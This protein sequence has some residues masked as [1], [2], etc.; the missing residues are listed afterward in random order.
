MQ[1]RW[2]RNLELMK[3]GLDWRGAADRQRQS[4]WERQPSS[5]S[6]NLLAFIMTE[7]TRTGFPLDRHGYSQ[8][9]TWSYMSLR[10]Q[11]S[12]IAVSW[13]FPSECLMTSWE[14]MVGTHDVTLQFCQSLPHNR[15]SA[16]RSI[17]GKVW[18]YPTGETPEVASEWHC[19]LFAT[20]WGHL[21]QTSLAPPGWFPPSLLQPP[22][23]L[24]AC[25]SIVSWIIS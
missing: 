5:E 20:S 15:K 8:G 17:Y 2:S 16:T 14:P 23:L 25:S 7:A 6:S 12:C 11:F 18:P 24:L 19:L 3:F 4:G 9:E 10:W 22:S 21:L 13:T 1:R